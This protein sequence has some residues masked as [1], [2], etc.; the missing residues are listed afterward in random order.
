[1]YSIE[2]LK[3]FLQ[4]PINLG[5]FN[6]NFLKVSKSLGVLKKELDLS[7]FVI[8]WILEDFKVICINTKELGKSH[9]NPRNFERF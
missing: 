4:F 3:D 1:M 6:Q 5:V 9:L 2:I 7:R 8:W